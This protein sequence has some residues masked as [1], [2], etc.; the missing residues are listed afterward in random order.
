[1]RTP[2]D[3]G[4]K[5]E[6]RAAIL[7]IQAGSRI[8]ARNFRCKL[9]EIDLIA[10]EPDGTLVFVEVKLRRNEHFGGAVGALRAAQ[11]RR[12]RRAA[13][14]FLAQHRELGSQPCRFDLIALRDVRD[15]EP[16]WLRNIAFY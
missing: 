8:L 5:A 13:Q 15:P 4:K 11:H 14:W 9:G 6:E 10:Q 3:A 12:A 2:A 16:Q 1:M 7:L